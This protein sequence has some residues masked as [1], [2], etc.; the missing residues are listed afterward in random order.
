MWVCKTESDLLQVIRYAEHYSKLSRFTSRNA[1]ITDVSLDKLV[2]LASG[3]SHTI[4]LDPPMKSYREARE[5]L[6]EMDH[7]TI[8]GLQRSKITVKEYRPPGNLYQ[9]VI[10]G[11]CL[12]TYLLLVRASTVLPGS[13][14]Y[15][16]LFKHIPAFAAFVLRVRL[17]VLIPMIAIHLGEVYIMLGRLEKH[18]VPLFSR[19]WWSW[20]GSCFIEGVGSFQ[21]Y[22]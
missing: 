15:K 16:V 20:V 5:R 4:A 13:V 22:V 8:A 6:V 7:E 11:L 10:F 1:T 21:R 9:I 19:L 17:W 14:P 2:L 12:G 18:S 3:S